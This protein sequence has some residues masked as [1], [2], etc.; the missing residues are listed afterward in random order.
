MRMSRA[1]SMNL[2]KTPLGKAIRRHI[3]EV[4]SQP[5][6]RQKTGQNL[7]AADERR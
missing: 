7:M 3:V 2:G 5:G 6:A 1:R 4:P